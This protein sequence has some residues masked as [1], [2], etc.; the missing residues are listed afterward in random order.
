MK[1]ILTALVAIPI[2]LYSVWTSTPYLFIALATAAILTGLYEFYS[3]ARRMDY[4]PQSIAG[5]LAAIGFIICFAARLFLWLPA[6]PALLVLISLVTV[7]YRGDTTPKAIGSVGAT[8]VGALYVGL[9][10]AFLIGLRAV[11]GY[12]IPLPVPN[13]AAKLLTTFFAMVMMTDTGAYYTGRAFGRHKLAPAISPGKTIEGSIG[14]FVT[15]AITG[16]LCRVIFFPE[17]Q[18]VDALVLGAIIGIVGQLGDLAESLLKR[19]AGVKDS[20]NIFPGHGGM[21]D[22]L[23]SLLFCAPVMYFYLMI[24]F[25]R[26][27]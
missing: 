24:F 20:G 7:I 26:Q 1:R 18:I 9:L 11:P 13:L 15:S 22:R 2:L 12:M 3:L 23:D 19:S 10:G 4:Q 27:F 21:L 17:F 8:V 5:Y 14:G 25:R 16:V 6:V